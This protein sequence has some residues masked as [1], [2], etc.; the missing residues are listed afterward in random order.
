MTAGAVIATVNGCDHLHFGIHPRDAYR[1]GNP[2]AGHVPKSWKDHG[3]WVDP[4]KY[5]KANP[6]A[7]TYVPP[8]LPV[9]RITTGSAPSR[10]G[11]AAG[12]AYWDEQVDGGAATY[13]YDLLAG[14][15]RQL[16]PGETAPAFDEVR[17]A[18]RDARRAGARDLRP[19]PAAGARAEARPLTPALGSA[20]QPDADA[21]QRRRASRSRVR[22]SQLER[23][24][25]AA[26]ARV[27]RRP[28]RRSEGTPSSRTRRRSAPC[29]VVQFL[30]PVVQPENG[31]LRR[32]PRAPWSPSL[33]RCASRCPRFR[34]PWR[35]AVAVTVAGSL[36]PRH[37]PGKGSVRLEFQ[38]LTPAGV[39]V[40]ARHRRA[41]CSAMAPR[42][43]CTRESVKLGNAG[44]WRV[45]AVHPED[46]A[47]AATVGGW[48]AFAVK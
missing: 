30:L 35:G 12:I 29:C 8:A 36:M 41:R 33:P 25:G 42:A 23:L 39:W 40:T 4:V 11:A 38:R 37:A 24:R 13:A 47:H 2:Y 43:R 28:H 46:E 7:A 17:Y 27:D 16:A 19:R 45:R 18:V 21:D 22:G 44:A 31:H 32:P 9:V 48:R 20:A 15:R 5:L 6:R 14:T 3:G 34:R 1:D 26:W 10:Y